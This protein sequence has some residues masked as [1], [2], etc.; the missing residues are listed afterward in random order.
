MKNPML[1]LLNFGMLY[2]TTCKFQKIA[3]KLT[4]MLFLD[5]LQDK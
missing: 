3:L 4:L 1:I 5:R 2:M